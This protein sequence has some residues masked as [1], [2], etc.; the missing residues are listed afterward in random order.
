VGLEWIRQTYSNKASEEQCAWIPYEIWIHREFHYRVL[1]TGVP[2]HGRGRNTLLLDSKIVLGKRPKINSVYQG[3]KRD[4]ILTF[5]LRLRIS[6]S[7]ADSVSGVSL[8]VGSVFTTLVATS[9]ER[10]IR[11]LVVSKHYEENK[12]TDWGEEDTAP[13]L[14]LR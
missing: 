2:W 4:I 3:D 10:T 8:E 1:S 6:A 14:L 13:I 7:E 5:S 11:S 12:Q 9:T